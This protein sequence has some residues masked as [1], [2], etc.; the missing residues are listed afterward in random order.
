MKHPFLVRLFSIICLTGASVS[1]HSQYYY[2]DITLTEQIN[3][4]FQSYLRNKVKAVKVIPS[5]GQASP[6]EE[7]T[8][9]RKVTYR[10]NK[11]ITYTKTSGFGESFL[12][13]LYDKDGLLIKSTDSTALSVS[14]SYYEYNAAHQLVQLKNKAVATDQ[15][16]AAE[17]V[18]TWAYDHN[19]KPVQMIR[20][21][22][23]TDTTL[24][25]LSLDD[26][27]NVE[28]E[29]VFR[30]GISQGRV[31]YYHDAQNRLTDVVRYNDRAQLMMPDYILEYENNGEL[32]AL[33][34]F[35]EWGSPQKWYYQYDD[36]GLKLAEFCYNKAEVL[37]VKVEYE[38]SF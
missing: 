25:K 22:D 32:S 3:E 5:G 34:I 16:S 9:S 28:E 13:A 19:G 2:K 31:Y 23:G 38:Y 1:A 15:S 11:V 17:E 6:A 18:H 26:K 20:V 4:T 33:T 7:F 35:P 27:G 10:P 30:D 36:N 37:Q 12:I 24:V 21:K 8:G 14:T 29:E